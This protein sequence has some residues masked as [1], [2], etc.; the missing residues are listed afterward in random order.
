[1]VHQYCNCSE[2]GHRNREG[3]GGAQGNTPSPQN[4]LFKVPFVMK[5]ALFVQANVIV[6]TI[7][8]TLKVPC[9]EEI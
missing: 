6:N 4:N 8:L 5:S 3:G 9:C 7:V 1:M 2:Q